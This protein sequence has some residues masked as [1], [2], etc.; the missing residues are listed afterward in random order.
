M[1]DG[2]PLPSIFGEGDSTFLEY[3]KR[4]CY[5][6]LG[7]VSYKMLMYIWSK[8]L[9]IILS[10]LLNSRMSGY[11]AGSTEKRVLKSFIADSFVMCGRLKV[12]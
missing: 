3:F 7:R 12:S 10:I 8:S 6:W 2:T 1:S 5:L 9:T 4:Y 11:L